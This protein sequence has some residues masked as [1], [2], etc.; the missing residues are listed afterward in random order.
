M[1]RQT[2][3]AVVSALTLIVLAG[4]IAFTPIPYVAWDPGVT[5]DVLGSSDGVEPYCQRA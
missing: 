3:T 5:N 1:T 4:V 2:W